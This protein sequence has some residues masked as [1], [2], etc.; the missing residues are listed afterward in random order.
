MLSGINMN[1]S[2]HNSSLKGLNANWGVSWSL[3]TDFLVSP[4]ASHWTVESLGTSSRNGESPGISPRTGESPGVSPQ[5]GESPG[6]SP[7]TL[8]FPGVLPWTEES[9]GVSPQT[10]ESPRVSPWI[11][12]S[13]GISIQIWESYGISSKTKESSGVSP[14][15][16][17]S[18]GDSQWTEESFV[19]LTKDWGVS[20]CLLKD[21]RDSWDPAMGCEVC[22]GLTT[23]WEITKDYSY[24]MRTC[25][26]L[27]S[28]FSCGAYSTVVWRSVF[29]KFWRRKKFPHRDHKFSSTDKPG[30]KHSWYRVRRSCVLIHSC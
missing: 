5:T 18:S 28:A 26:F 21:W 11:G 7:W 1:V 9:P 6:I 8:E 22:G 12:E 10:W 2:V 15:T 17:K 3:A 27:L 13:P 24:C 30:F 16:W 23:G 29:L 4:V 25:F 14:R 20:V 19:N